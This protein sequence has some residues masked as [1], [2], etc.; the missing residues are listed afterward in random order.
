MRKWISGVVFICLMMVISGCS[1]SLKD[2]NDDAIKNVEEAFNHKSEK[3]TDGSNNVKFYLPFGMS[4]K[5][6]SP[7]NVIIKGKNDYILFYNQNE[8]EDSK[9]VYQM[10]KPEK[11]L[12]VDHTIINKKQFGYLIVSKVEKDM[13]EVT[14]GIG[15]IK[16]TTESKEKNISANASKMMR[17][18]KSVQYK[19]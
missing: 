18:V 7:N 8:K 2:E 10:S 6:E 12:V 14:V 4:I 17:V 3:I 1:H 16:M 11:N 19:K 9:I 13:Y 15:G 5:D